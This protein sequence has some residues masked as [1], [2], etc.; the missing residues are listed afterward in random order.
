MKRQNKQED[1]VFDT[2]TVKMTKKDMQEC[3]KLIKKSLPKYLRS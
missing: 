3:R 1:L 2:P